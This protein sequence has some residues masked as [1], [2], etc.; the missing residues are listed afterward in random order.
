MSPAYGFE[1]WLK[2]VQPV[3]AKTFYMAHTSKASVTPQHTYISSR[4]KT[5]ET[6]GHM[7]IAYM[8]L[9]FSSSHRLHMVDTPTANG[10]LGVTN[11]LLHTSIN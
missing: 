4:G 10:T 2:S 5:I 1:W 11:S 8:G 6:L 9:A 3:G 7:Q